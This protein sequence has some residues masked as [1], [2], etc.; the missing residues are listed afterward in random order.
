M[1]AKRDQI[2]AAYREMDEHRHGDVEKAI[3]A[4]HRAFD[5]FRGDR[6]FAT[7]ERRLYDDG[8]AKLRYIVSQCM[9]WPLAAEALSDAEI[10]NAQLKAGR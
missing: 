3:K 2:L 9:D 4:W 7:S 8:H 5:I 1:N 10:F 6:A